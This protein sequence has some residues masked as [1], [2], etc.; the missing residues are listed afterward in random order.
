MGRAGPPRGRRRAKNA[1]STLTF[2]KMK[3]TRRPAAASSV[4]PQQ[5]IGTVLRAR[6]CGRQARV[7]QGDQGA[8]DPPRGAAGAARRQRGPSAMYDRDIG[9]F[10]SK[11]EKNVEGI[12]VYYDRAREFH[13]RGIK[14]RGRVRA[15]TSASAKHL[16]AHDLTARS[17]PPSAHGAPCRASAA[18]SRRRG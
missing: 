1:A 6:Q 10:Q 14:R 12:K 15:A 11:N 8:R 9:P 13:G 18:T 7:W 2:H 17:P 4:E 16:L 5:L 3:M